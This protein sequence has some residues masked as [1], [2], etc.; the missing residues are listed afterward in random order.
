MG[1][2]RESEDGPDGIAKGGFDAVAIRQA[3]TRVAESPGFAAS[4]RMRDFLGYVVEETLSGRAAEIKGF[5]IAMEVFGRGDKFD[6]ANDSV[7]RVEAARLRRLLAAYYAAEGRDDPILIEIPKGTYVP[8][9][10]ARANRSGEAAAGAAA[11]SGAVGGTAGKRGRW[12]AMLA[13]AAAGVAVLAGS[14]LLWPKDEAVPPMPDEASEL[15]RPAR[16]TVAVLPFEATLGGERDA[17]LGRG[18]AA[19]ISAALTGFREIVVLYADAGPQAGPDR[20]DALDVSRY[21]LSGTVASQRGKLRVLVQLRDGRTNQSLW[22]QNYERS[23]DATD[24]FELQNEISGQVASTVADPYGVIW[25][26][27]VARP[28][29]PKSVSAYYCVL[30]AYDYWRQL[31]APLHGQVRDCLEQA[32]VAEPQYADAWAALAFLHMDEHRYGYNPRPGKPPLDRALEAA[33]HAVA[34]DSFDAA[35]HQAVYTVYFLREDIEQFRRFGN[36]ALELNSNSL[37]LAGDFGAKL[38]MSG[39]WDEGL[40]MVRRVLERNP[41][42]PGWLFTPLIY[43]EYRNGN[44]TAA[45]AYLERMNTPDYY[46]VYV[47]QAMVYGQM[48]E[49]AKAQEALDRI[50]RLRPDFLADPVAEMSHWGLSRDLLE[51][52][53]DGLKKAGVAIADV[54]G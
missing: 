22:A 13:A 19:D 6:P 24:L 44:Y 12:L 33:K 34:L 36:K 25:R 30:R 2:Q 11:A 7:V 1:E 27:E 16:P 17:L 28:R 9:F 26:S 31:S 18:L 23:L 35:A 14:L 29:P 10:R 38:A 45:L 47:L 51:R 39:F 3:L 4:P 53:I 37:D 5:T 52:S 32:V 40:P 54:E 48:G 50:G 41:A 49:Y 8:L 46:R 15:I 21:V 20:V 42:P 43:D